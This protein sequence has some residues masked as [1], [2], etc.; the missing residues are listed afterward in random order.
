VE[1]VPIEVIYKSEQSKIHPW[2]DT[3]RWFGWLRRWPS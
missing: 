2:R 3:L 1:F